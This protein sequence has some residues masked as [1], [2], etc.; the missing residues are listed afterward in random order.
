MINK[1]K[2][3]IDENN[4]K[5]EMLRELS[6]VLGENEY[7][8]EKAMIT[9]KEQQ[10]KYYTFFKDN[11]SKNFLEKY[12]WCQR[13]CDTNMSLKR[14]NKNADVCCWMSESLAEQNGLEKIDLEEFI[15]SFVQPILKE[16]INLKSKLEENKKYE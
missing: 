14:F 1:R 2:L 5:Y 4:N 10:E 13:P 9:Y 8:L 12:N 6:R 3:E 16:N 11:D 7:F 15:F